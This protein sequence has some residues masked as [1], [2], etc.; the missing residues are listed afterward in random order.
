M[1]RFAKRGRSLIIVTVLVI[2]VVGW[3]ASGMIDSGTR[4]QSAEASDKKAK[5]V[6]FTVAIREEKARE[7]TRFVVVQ[8]SLKAERSVTIRSEV[9]GTIAEI[10]A[11]KGTRLKA[12]D[13][14]VRVSVDDRQ[15]QLAKA[16]AAL[17][18]A[19]RDYEAA[20]KLGER[21]FQTTARIATLKADLESAKAALRSVEIELKNLTVRAPFDGVL[22]DRFVEKGDLLAVKDKVGTLV[23]ADPIIALADISQQNIAEIKLGGVAQVELVNGKTAMGKISFISTEASE[24]TRT[25][26]VEIRVANSDGAIRAGS[27]VGVRIP[28]EKVMAHFVSPQLLVLGRGENA[29]G[30]MTVSDK[31]VVRFAKVEIVRATATGVWVRGL[32]ESVRIIVRGQGFV[33]PGQTVKVKR[34]AARKPK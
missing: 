25:F 15:A 27:T 30:V 10:L 3:M 13:P 32:P 29:L 12:G 17:A 11:K 1:S 21:G 24:E 33:R 26:R 31:N 16:K 5:T 23:D 19:V 6:E 4:A 2:G 28:V 22:N 8:G 14:I 34:L 20:Q 7:I 9:K 18:K